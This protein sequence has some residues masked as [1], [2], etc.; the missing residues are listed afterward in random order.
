MAFR[1]RLQ[2]TIAAAFALAMI[3]LLVA[4]VGYVYHSNSTLALETAAASMDQASRA[5]DQAPSRQVST[6]GIMPLV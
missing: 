3:P 4:V 5:G 6:L 2:F 1:V